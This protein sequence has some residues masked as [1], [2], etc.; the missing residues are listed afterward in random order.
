MER[1]EETSIPCHKKGRMDRPSVSCQK[2]VS[3]T[4]LGPSPPH[5]ALPHQLLQ[6]TAIEGWVLFATGIHEE[7]QEDDVYDAFAEFGDVKN[8]QLNLD[9]QT[10]Y[11]KGYAV[12]EYAEKAEA[13]A[14]IDNLDGKELLTQTI[15]VDWAFHNGPLRRPRS[16]QR[17]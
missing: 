12:V 10:G 11:V 16:G 17:S 8:V 5:C 6:T 1:H 14:A 3:F 15:R 13:Q 9:R 4:G 7:A 2:L